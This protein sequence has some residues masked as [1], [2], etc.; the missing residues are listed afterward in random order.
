MNTFLGT[1]TELSPA[2]LDPELIQGSRVLYL[3][4]YS[5]DGPNAKQAFYEAAA[6]AREAR[7][8]VSLTLSDPFC[9]ER[10]REAF[11]DF[12]RN[13]VDLLFA[14]HREVMSLYQT[15]DLEDACR[16]LSK[17]CNLAA[18]TRS[19]KGSWILTADELYEIAPEPVAHVADTTGAGDL[20]AAGF[21]F[22]Y[23]RSMEMPACGRLASLAAAEIISHIG[24]RPEVSLA[25]LA[26][27]KGAL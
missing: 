24:P 20:Y 10:H 26:R 23:A 6:I 14:N 2:E 9:V 16:Q 17:D 1:N 15:E 18:V 12:I 13:S 19:E 22:G 11:L 7:T 21:L 4:G 3:E 5:F 25:E 8:T 27:S